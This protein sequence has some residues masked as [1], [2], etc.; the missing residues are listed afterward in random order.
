MLATLHGPVDTNLSITDMEKRLESHGFV[1]CHRSYLV[2]LRHIRRIAKTCALLD[3]GAEVPL[4]RSAYH[5]VNQA[6]IAYYRGMD[7]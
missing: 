2:G 4:S 3:N 1:R 5:K 6:F 7:Q